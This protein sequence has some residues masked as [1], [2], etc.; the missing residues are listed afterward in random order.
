[1]NIKHVKVNFTHNNLIYLPSDN[2]GYK[3]IN[4]KQLIT[5]PLYVLLSIIILLLSV[6]GNPIKT[7]FYDVFKFPLKNIKRKK[8]RR[9]TA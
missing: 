7:M 3:N 1:M 6:T 2:M 9:S 8:K 4:D 5:L